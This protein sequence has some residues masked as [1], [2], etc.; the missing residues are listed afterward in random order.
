VRIQ[1]T[2]RSYKPQQFDEIGNETNDKK[3]NGATIRKRREEK[4]ISLK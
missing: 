1:K 4:E 3:A 2:N